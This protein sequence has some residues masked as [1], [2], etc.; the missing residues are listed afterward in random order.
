M[1]FNNNPDGI[2]IAKDV[3]FGFLGDKRLKGCPS[4]QFNKLMQAMLDDKALPYLSLDELSFAGHK[5]ICLPAVHK[6]LKKVVSAGKVVTQNYV[7]TEN[8]MVIIYFQFSETQRAIHIC[9]PPSKD[10]WQ[11]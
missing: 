3:W 2:M 1:V 4:K 8:R 11:T 9:T 10:T 5:E 7:I 6:G